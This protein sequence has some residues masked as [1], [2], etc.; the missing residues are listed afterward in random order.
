V[1]PYQ[2]L[3]DDDVAAAAAQGDITLSSEGEVYRCSVIGRKSQPGRGSPNGRAGSMPAYYDDALFTIN[4]MELPDDAAEA[5]L[6]HNR[7]VNVIYMRDAGLPDGG[8]FVALDTIQGD[9]FNPLWLEVQIAFNPG[10]TPRQLTG[11]DAVLDA[12]L[13]GEITLSS[14]NE[15]YRCSVIGP[16]K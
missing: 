15:V 3:S 9:G 1:T 2:L 8:P 11:D 6:E 4:F 12:A 13:S 14:E 16:R 10:F 5:V 7:S